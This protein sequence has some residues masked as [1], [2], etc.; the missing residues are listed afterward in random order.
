MQ[1]VRPPYRLGWLDSIVVGQDARTGALLLGEAPAEHHDGHSSAGVFLGNMFVTQVTRRLKQQNLPV[2]PLH[3]HLHSPSCRSLRPGV[4]DLVYSVLI[5]EKRDFFLFLFLFILAQK[6]DS[7]VHL[8]VAPCVLPT[9]TA[10][11]LRFP[12]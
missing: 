1:S 9:H 12:C 11:V 8:F 5:H 10:S 7:V 4:L 2:P 6:T 3:P